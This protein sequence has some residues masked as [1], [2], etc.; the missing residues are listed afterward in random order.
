MHEMALADAVVTTALKEA[1][2]HGLSKITEIAV[3][4]GELQQIDR[5]VFAFAL[6]EVL[7]AAE[8]RLAGVRFRIETEPA[9]FRCRPCGRSFGT[10]DTAGP[11]GDDE[12]EA[13]HFVPE[14]AH[15]FLRCPDCSSPDFEVV[16]GRGVGL[17]SIEG[18]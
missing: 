8:P 11:G 7:P 5:E 6:Q 14:L 9:L 13:I 4:V 17:D 2:K 3:R 1:G 10:A 15:A 16:Q 12:A 18:E